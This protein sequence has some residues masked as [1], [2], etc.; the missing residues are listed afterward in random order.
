M[1]T[2]DHTTDG[3]ENPAEVSLRFRAKIER[4]GTL[5]VEDS[6]I[7]RTAVGAM[8]WTEGRRRS[9]IARW[10]GITPGAVSRLLRG[11]PTEGATR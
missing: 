11:K 8:F 5:S 7:Y 10:L 3:V 2:Q 6:R 9:W 4:D 1:S